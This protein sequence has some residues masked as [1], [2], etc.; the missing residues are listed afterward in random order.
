MSYKFTRDNYVSTLPVDH[1]VIEKDDLQLII[2]TFD[3]PRGN[4]AIMAFKG[5]ANKP[6]V[7]KAYFTTEDRDQAVKNIIK[8]RKSYLASV[9]KRRKERNKPH[10]LKVGDILH[11]SWGYDQTN[12]D[13][14]QVTKLIGKTMVEIREIRARVVDTPHMTYQNVAPVADSFK[15]EPMRKKV[16][17]YHNSVSIYSFANA[18]PHDG[19]P[20]Y[21]TALGF[22]H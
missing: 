17:G 2:Y 10:T 16:D 22:G 11:C 20:D 18:Y 15:G 3:T 4:P 1:K 7:Y 12:N 13:Y 19:K 5:K 6:A 9:E 14:F 8:N 21:E